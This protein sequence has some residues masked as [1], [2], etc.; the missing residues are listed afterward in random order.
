VVLRMDPPST[1]RDT[2]TQD[3]FNRDVGIAI[4][5]EVPEGALTAV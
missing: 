4:G 3:A 5:N 1:D 2:T